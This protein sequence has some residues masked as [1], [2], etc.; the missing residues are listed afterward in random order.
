MSIPN[1]TFFDKIFINFG[2]KNWYVF[3]YTYAYFP[4]HMTE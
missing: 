2:R 4:L 3:L 1:S